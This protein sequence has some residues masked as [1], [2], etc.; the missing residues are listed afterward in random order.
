[1]PVKAAMVIT[2]TQLPMPNLSDIG[3]SDHQVTNSGL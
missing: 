1:V 3:P 2:Q